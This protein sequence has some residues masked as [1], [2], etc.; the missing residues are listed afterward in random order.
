MGLLWMTVLVCAAAVLCSLSALISG[1]TFFGSQI[2]SP[3]Y[4]F[5][6]LAVSA[7]CFLISLAVLVLC[8]RKLRAK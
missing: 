2:T 5:G 7:A 6:L 8:Y 3:G 4:W 1:R